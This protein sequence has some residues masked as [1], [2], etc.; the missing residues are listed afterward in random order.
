[1]NKFKLACEKYIKSQ[2]QKNLTVQN[3]KLKLLKLTLR[4]K[5]NK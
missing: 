2:P 4:N 5:Q 1:M 3:Y